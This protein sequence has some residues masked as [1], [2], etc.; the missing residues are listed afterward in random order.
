MGAVI[1]VVVML[2]FGVGNLPEIGAGRGRVIR[3]FRVGSR[4]APKED[5]Q[6]GNEPS[7]VSI[8]I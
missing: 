2:I 7:T 1:L 4:V 5:A 3:E 8:V 6:A